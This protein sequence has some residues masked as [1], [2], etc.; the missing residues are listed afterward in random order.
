MENLTIQTKTKKKNFKRIMQKFFSTPAII[1]I[2]AVETEE[3]QIW[4][5][6]KTDYFLFISEILTKMGLVDEVA[7]NIDTF[8]KY[9]YI[10]DLETLKMWLN[11]DDCIK[12]Y[13][14]DEANKH[15]S[16]RRSMSTKSVDIVEI[17]P[18]ISKA[19]ARLIIIA[20]KISALDSQLRDF[21]WVKGR[22]Y[23]VD[24]KTVYIISP[25]L[26]GQYYF[27]NIPPTTIKFNPYQL[28]PFTLKPTGP[29][30][31]LY[32]DMDIQNSVNWA[33]GNMPIEW[34]KHPMEIHRGNKKGIKAM[35]LK[36][37]Q[38]TSISGRGSTDPTIT[39]L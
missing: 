7:T 35:V 34:R 23:K 19:R 29:T 2:G 11:K 21:G 20:H 25:L 15:L 33:D 22:M 5:I 3:S 14:L 10:N 38:L 6:G 39:N 13:G 17:F 8:G 32:N 18:E 9:P 36:L 1:L 12:L 28:A 4:K 27:R 37:S 26:K 30:P 16:S 24:L 31:L